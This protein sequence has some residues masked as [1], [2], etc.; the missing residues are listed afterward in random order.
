MKRKDHLRPRS[1]AVLDFIRTEVAA[2]MG[3][4]A[5]GRIG[6]Y[7][8]WKGSQSGR[9]ALIRL[10]AAGYLRMEMVT[11][12]GGRWAYAFSLAETE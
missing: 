1:A 12:S 6:Q 8:G 11:L 9:D 5:P 10:A 3:I 4:P 2:G 7:M